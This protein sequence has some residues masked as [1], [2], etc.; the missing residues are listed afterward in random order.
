MSGSMCIRNH[1]SSRQKSQQAESGE[2]TAIVLSDGDNLL[3]GTF[4]LDDHGCP[5]LMF[6]LDRFVDFLTMDWNFGRGFDPQPDFVAAN[7][8]DGDLDIVAD[9]NAFIALTG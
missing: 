4:D 3:D 7:I 6:A 5:A 2:K 1:S 9:E 8:D